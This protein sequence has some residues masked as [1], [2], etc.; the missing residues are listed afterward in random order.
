MS[1]GLPNWKRRFGNPSD[2]E[3]TAEQQARDAVYALPLEE[4]KARAN[5][6]AK[7]VDAQRREEYRTQNA[8]SWRATPGSARYKMTPSNA[9][10]MVAALDEFKMEG[11]VVDLQTVFDHLSSQGSLELNLPTY[12]PKPYISQEEF[13]QLSVEEMRTAMEQLKEDGIF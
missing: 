6:E 10:K 8:H 7:Q 13:S 1:S 3:P 11:S 2:F 5:E 12:T 9:E 4:L